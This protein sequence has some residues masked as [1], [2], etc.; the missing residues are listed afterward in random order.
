MWLSVRSVP[1]FT[2]LKSTGHESFL[3]TWQ[4]PRTWP[5]NRNR[6][7]TKYRARGITVTSWDMQ[8]HCPFPSCPRPPLFSSCR[9]GKVSR[10][11]WNTEPHS[12]ERATGQRGA[13]DLHRVHIFTVCGDLQ[14]YPT[15]SRFRTEGSSTFNRTVSCL[16]SRLVFWEGSRTW[17]RSRRF[18][19]FIPKQIYDCDRNLRGDISTS[20]NL[21]RTCDFRYLKITTNGHADPDKNLASIY[22]SVPTLS[23]HANTKN[24]TLN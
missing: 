4:R 1:A 11:D 21:A 2:A 13:K 7:L 17:K 6:R 14:P 23:L 15:Q 24:G 12:E 18:L 16:Q 20:S 8:G 19:E 10:C 5:K 22:K 3:S 9:L